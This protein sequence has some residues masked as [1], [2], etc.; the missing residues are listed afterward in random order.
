M[1]FYKKINEITFGYIENFCQQKISENIVLD[2]KADF[3]KPH[4]DL[5][6]TISAFANTYGGVIIIGIEQDDANKPKLPP[7]GIDFVRGLHEKVVQID[8]DNIF[9]PV[10]PQ[11]QVVD[12]RGSKTFVVIRVCPSNATPHSV[13]NRTM[14]YLRTDNI[15]RPER[16]ATEEE[17]GWLRNNRQKSEE[18]KDFI[19]H[20]ISQRRVNIEYRPLL[21]TDAIPPASG[22]ARGELSICPLYPKDILIKPE[23]I[24]GLISEIAVKDWFGSFN[25]FP[26]ISSNPTPTFDG[27]MAYYIETDGDRLYYTE[28]NQ[29]GFI[30]HHESFA[31]K[32]PLGKSDEKSK[33][34]IS[35]SQLIA[36]LDIF[37]QA[38]HNFYKNIGYWGYLELKFKL[39]NILG[40]TLIPAQ[41]A[42]YYLG[43]CQYI[44]SDRHL[45]IEKELRVDELGENREELVIELVKKVARV[46]GW[47]CPPDSIKQM[48]DRLK[49]H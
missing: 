21:I 8:L 9:P 12:P 32:G 27:F 46:F 18:L 6:K 1:V 26:D 25:N 20:K 45:L 39:D 16:R 19:H 11:V 31:R 43:N 5:A 36:R 4:S 47:D 7:K 34:S 49:K 24:E 13:E 10:L 35:M 38:A 3:T 17:R 42:T 29:Y 44:P 37:T 23:K 33:D 41:N 28:I 30:F 48:W 14:V 22:K 15:N 40:F 2:Y